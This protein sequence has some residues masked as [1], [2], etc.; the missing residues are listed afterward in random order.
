MV[1]LI[2]RVLFAGGQGDRRGDRASLF[3][4]RPRVAVNVADRASRSVHDRTAC[5][6]VDPLAPKLPTGRVGTGAE[7][8]GRAEVADGA[9][10]GVT[11]GPW[12]DSRGGRAGE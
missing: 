6:S 12:D 9:G 2:G 7:V 3:G 8:A 1:R 4:G 10:S 5:E 11:T